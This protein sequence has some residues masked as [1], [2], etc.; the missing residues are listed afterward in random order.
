[1]VLA[2]PALFDE[3]W[4]PAWLHGGR[5]PGLHERAD[6]K[7]TLVS[8]CVPRWRPIS[9]WNFEAGKMGPKAARRLAPAGSVFFFEASGGTS[10]LANLWLW[11]MSDLPQDRKDGFGLALWGDWSE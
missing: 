2:T 9:G 10:A 8:A 4:K 1:M 5:P 6:V 11:P 7:L 3:G